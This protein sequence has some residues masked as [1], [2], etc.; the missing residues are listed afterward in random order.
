M[1]EQS[2]G[3]V[4]VDAAEQRRQRSASREARMHHLINYIPQRR[5]GVFDHLRPQR[6][7]WYLVRRPIERSL[8]QQTP[9]PLTI[10]QLNNLRHF[11]L[12]GIFASASE[13]FYLAFIPLFALAYGATNQEVGWITAIGNLAGAAALFPGARLIEKTGN[14]K[15]IVLWSGGGVARVVLLLLACI[16]LLSLPPLAAIL[17]ITALN[18]VRAFAANFANPAWTAMVADIVPEYMRGRYFSVRNLTMGLAT[19]VFSATAG[20]LIRAGNHWQGESFLGYQ[21]SF[22][23]AF[24]LGMASTYQFARLRE[25]HSQRHNEQVRQSGSL[26]DAVRSSPGYLGFVLSGFVWNFALQVA[27]PFFNVY[28]VTR[29]GANASTV[30]LFASISSLTSMVGQMFFGRVLDR[31]GAVFL[32]LVTGFP[33]VLL[34]VMWIFYTEAWQA[35]VNNL[36]GGFLWAGF[37]LAN[38]NLLLQVTPNVGRARAVALYQTGVFASAFIGPLLGGFLAD[39]VS[40]QSIFLL[41]GIG[42][43]AGMLI[44]LAMTF[45]P[46]RRLAAQKAAGA[47]A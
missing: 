40:F 17:L 25:P 27:A 44:F 29:L 15:A 10:F 18:G 6:W 32:Q 26:R 35:G 30:G 14:R 41:S 13:S 31:R 12:D 42:R 46:L 3:S 33:I 4:G 5:I 11:W 16:P 28:L 7:N 20:W 21:L 22:L 47:A 24:L 19:L 36:F 45:I 37:N 8:D 23:L 9:Q 39:Q 1:S 43:L 38:F 2:A 34:P